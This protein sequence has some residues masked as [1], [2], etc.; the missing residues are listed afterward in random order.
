[1]KLRVAATSDRGLVRAENEDAFIAS[2]PL[3]VVADGVGGQ[4]AGEIASALAVEVLSEWKPRLSARRPERLREAA[5]DANHRIYTRAQSDTSLQ[6]M[7]TTLTAA[8]IEGGTCTVAQIGD[9]RAYL[10]RDGVLE[11]LT[12]DQSAVAE[13]VKS[14]RISPEEAYTHPWRNRILQALGG[15]PDVVVDMYSIDLRVG[16]RLLIASDGLTDELR[17]DVLREVLSTIEDPEVA[18][19]TLISRAKEAGG[20]DNITVALVDV[21]GNGDDES[22]RLQRAWTTLNRPI[23]FRRTR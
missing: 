19:R 11:Q 14:G 12:E 16:D 8:W 9:S 5:R 22:S 17:D 21:T 15:A 7:A 1:M 6:G 18:G 23:T 10:Y 20:R 2:L 4:N 3:V 13:L